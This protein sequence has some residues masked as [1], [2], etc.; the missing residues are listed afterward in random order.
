VDVREKTATLA[1]GLNVLLTV[2]K[3]AL[4]SVTGSLA[5]LAEAWHSFSDI[6]TSALTYVA[7][8]RTVVREK[9]AARANGGDEGG[10]PGVSSGEIPS[11]PVDAEAD[12]QATRALPSAEQI[13]SLVIGVVILIAGL[14]LLSKVLWYQPIV[15]AKPLLAGVLFIAFA[16]GSYLVHRL[17]IDVGQKTGSSGLVADGM[18]ARADMIASLLTGASLILYH[19]GVNLD[20]VIA[21]LIALLILSLAVETIVNLLVG[22]ARGEM[23]YVPRYR[24]HE[25]LVKALSASWLSQV[26]GRVMGQAGVPDVASRFVGRAKRW[27]KPGIIAI[28]VVLYGRTCFFTVGLGQEGIVEHLGKP[29][30]RAV[31]PGFHVRWPWPIDRVLLVDK[32]NV[33]TSRVGNETDPLA[34]ALI[35]TREHGTEVSFVAGDEGLFFPYIVVHWRIK[36]TFDVVF[37]QQEATILLDAV[38]HQT[39]S[40][41]CAKR[42]FYDIACAYRKKLPEELRSIVQARLDELE[43]GLE[44]VSVNMSDVHPP[45]SIASS[46]EEVVV[47]EYQETQQMLN[48]ALGYKNQRLADARGQ[49]ARIK[50]QAGVYKTEQVG[51]AKGLGGRFTLHAAS[52]SEGRDVSLERMYFDHVTDSLRDIPK[53]LI[54]PEVG[55]PDLWM[56][57]KGPIGSS[58]S[59]DQ[60]AKLEDLRGQME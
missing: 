45:V 11:Q 46:F 19:L 40:E 57:F 26:A 1:T 41:L 59:P 22:Y 17:E 47:A 2:A 4:Y 34:F 31:Q 60:A 8:R 33:R 55:R 42:E 28:V 35:W 3:F 18:H 52:L 50:S 43:S 16:V 30:R 51:R 44:I 56:G 54:E 38:T 32:N 21:A 23:R 9:Q 53:V 48:E 24:S 36:D 25:I 7:V 10:S 39:L 27:V 20:R 14:T 15:L 6:A 12:T 58:L 49:A 5:I 29:T 13:T 37:R